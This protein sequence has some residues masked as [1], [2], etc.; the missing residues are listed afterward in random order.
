MPDP[1]CYRIATLAERWDCSE[2]KV[3]SLIVEGA[4]E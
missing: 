1:T 4:R 3:R 2:G